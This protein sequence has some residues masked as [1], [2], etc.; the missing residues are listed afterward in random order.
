MMRRQATTVAVRA[1]GATNQ[2]SCGEPNQQSGVMI[3]AQTAIH[4]H[5]VICQ[6]SVLMFK[7]L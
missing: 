5:G 4:R 1:D 6:N 7:C 2:K 3:S